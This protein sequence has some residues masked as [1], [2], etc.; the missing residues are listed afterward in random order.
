M[1]KKKKIIVPVDFSNT[2]HNAYLYARAL[3]K[4]IGAKV[5]VIHVHTVT[6]KEKN[7]DFSK[8]MDLIR[9][10]LADF[11]NVYPGEEEE[12]VTFFK[13]KL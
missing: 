8:K 5:E 1:N 2:S 9:A 10:K 3:A 11:V 7:P 12:G 6:S 13:A 4:D